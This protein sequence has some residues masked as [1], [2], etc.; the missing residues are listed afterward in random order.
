MT[1]AVG[2]DAR[3][4]RDFG[5]GTYTRG[6]IGALA[7]LPEAAGFRFALFA[8]P[9]DEP[10]FASLSICVFIGPHSRMARRFTPSSR[11]S[12]SAVSV[13]LAKVPGKISL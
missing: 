9:G 10:L 5:I 7:G 6:L 11:S 8:R 3:K 2:I 4:A 12:Q 13:V 1:P